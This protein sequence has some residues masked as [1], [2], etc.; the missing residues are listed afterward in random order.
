[1]EI[2]RAKVCRIS[3][4]NTPAHGVS[5]LVNSS[6]VVNLL[7]AQSTRFEVWIETIAINQF[8]LSSD[9]RCNLF[10]SNVKQF[11]VFLV[12]FLSSLSSLWKKS[13]LIIVQLFLKTISLNIIALHSLISLWALCPKSSQ[14]DTQVSVIKQLKATV[15]IFFF[16]VTVAGFIAHQTKEDEKWKKSS[17]LIV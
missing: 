3:I 5:E 15:C 12:F 4:S 1:M 16:F 14:I 8:E 13:P 9:E 17:T 11:H 10:K 2:D 7:L 6:N